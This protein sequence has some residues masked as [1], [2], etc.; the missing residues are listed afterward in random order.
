MSYAAIAAW[1][2]GKRPVW[3]Y[4]LDL[5]QES[6]FYTS[7]A[8]GYVTTPDFFDRFDFFD[9]PDVFTRTWA[10]SAIAHSRIRQTS[11]IGRA[12]TAL[13]LPNS[14]AFAR[15]FLGGQGIAESRVTIWHGFSNDPDGEL[16][17]KFRGRVVGVRPMLTRIT[18]ICEN[19]FTEMRRKGLS[20]VMQQ[21]CRHALY[22][23]G[24]G[25]N[26]ADWQQDLTA[27]AASGAFLTVPGAATEA[28]GHYSGGVLSFGGQ[29]QMILKH[30]GST[31][32]LLKPMPDL[33]EEIAAWGSAA[34]KLA[35]GCPLTLDACASKFNNA[36]NFGGFPWM[37]DSPFDGRN[38]F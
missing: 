3:L 32:R 18:L 12:E 28:D 9:E 5:G 23:G 13:V 31:L 16:V 27:T 1:V 33:S 34:V 11:A 30:T 24:C 20:A 35:P 8:G 14:D 38:I 29:M 7:R 17:V 4:R 15:R 22:H 6:V 10:P 37:T 2:S 25:L 21:P 26:I 36:L 19:R